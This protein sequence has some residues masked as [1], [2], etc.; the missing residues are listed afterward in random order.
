MPEQMVM[1]DLLV[2]VVVQEHLEDWYDTISKL[3]ITW[4]D[5][6]IWEQAG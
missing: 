2:K 3:F 1:L 4:V 5:V 6:L